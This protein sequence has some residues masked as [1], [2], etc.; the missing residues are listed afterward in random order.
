MDRQH[1]DRDM[2]HGRE[3]L[4]C[5]IGMKNRHAK[6][7]CGMETQH[8]HAAF[9]FLG[10]FL[11]SCSL[12]YSHMFIQHV[13]AKYSCSTGMQMKMHGRHSAW[14][15]GHAAL[16]CIMSMQKGHAA[17]IHGHAGLTSSIACICSMDKQHGHA[18]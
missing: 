1:G 12:K 9:S 11:C 5:N 18:A 17:W 15:H 10:S 13:H 2:E 3:A 14:S 7:S 8:V 6:W 4:T 16:I